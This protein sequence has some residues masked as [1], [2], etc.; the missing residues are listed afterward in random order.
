M[1][2]SDRRAALGIKSVRPVHVR[3]AVN[4]QVDDEDEPGPAKKQRQT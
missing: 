4:I 2:F 1:P 3:K